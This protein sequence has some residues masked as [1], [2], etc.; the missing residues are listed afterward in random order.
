MAPIV[1][2]PER[3]GGSA[4]PSLVMDLGRL[5]F[6]NSA[7]AAARSRE[8]LLAE[9]APGP[10]APPGAAPPAETHD[11]AAAR[12]CESAEEYASS[13][14]D[15][16][17]FST[18][19]EDSLSDGGYAE[20]GDES[21]ALLGARPSARAR[22]DSNVDRWQLSMSSISLTLRRSSAASA[23]DEEV[24]FT[25][26]EKF[27]ILLDVET[28]YRAGVWRADAAA[29]SAAA[30]V[31]GEVAAAG[32]DAESPLS[33]L[34]VTGKLPRLR[35]MLNSVSVQTAHRVYRQ[36]GAWQ[37]VGR[38]VRDDGDGGAGAGAGAA[39]TA[40]PGIELLLAAD[41]STESRE[42]SVG[43][44]SS[45]TVE[46]N[47]EIKHMVVSLAFGDEH[48]NSGDKRRALIQLSMRGLGA[49]LF[50][51]PAL[52]EWGAHLN[53][54]VVRDRWQPYG[55][56]WH[57]ATLATSSPSDEATELVA[58]ERRRV[59]VD[60]APRAQR[61]RAS[62]AARFGR[63]RD[64]SV[65]C[66]ELLGPRARRLIQ[67]TFTERRNDDGSTHY[68]RRARFH[69]LH[70]E[71][72]PETISALF[73]FK[74]YAYAAPP[75]DDASAEAALSVGANDAPVSGAAAA[76]AEEASVVPPSKMEWDVRVDSVSFCLNKE[77]GARTL[78]VI[79]LS[80]V[81]ARVASAGAKVSADV[82]LGNLVC[83]DP[84]PSAVH[85]EL[86]RLKG[87]G[88]V[89]GASSQQ[90]E[91]A[92]AV[93]F[94]GG[95]AF[96][97]AEYGELRVEL[98]PAHMVY[99]HQT[100]MEAIDYITAGFL[101]TLLATSAA[102]AGEMVNAN[103]GE[104]DLRIVKVLRIN[105]PTVE[106]PCSTESPL[107]LV[108]TLEDGVDITT[109]FEARAVGADAP[110]NDGSD[111]GGD[112]DS[113][114]V[115]QEVLSMTARGMMVLCDGR[116]LLGND[117]TL[118]IRHAQSAIREG[119][120]GDPIWVT[121][122]EMEFTGE[123][124]RGVE[125]SLA[126]SEYIR[127]LEVLYSNFGELAR[128][129]ATAAA[130]SVQYRYG[131]TS[132]PR[133][134]RS[135]LTLSVPSM[136]LRI[137]RDR[138]SGE[139]D[140]AVAVDDACT[141][142]AELDTQAWTLTSTSTSSLSMTKW[143]V[144]EGSIRNLLPVARGAARD[145]VAS[146]PLLQRKHGASAASGPIITLTF[147]SHYDDAG[148]ERAPVEAQSGYHFNFNEVRMILEWDAVKEVADFF[149]GQTVGEIERFKAACATAAFGG[150]QHS[151]VV[152][153]SYG[154]RQGLTADEHYSLFN[155]VF[156]NNIARWSVSNSEIW[157][158]QEQKE[159]GGAGGRC[160]AVLATGSAH[161]QRTWSRYSPQRSMVAL[162]IIVHRRA[163]AADDAARVR[164]VVGQR[165]AE[166]LAVQRTTTGLAKAM[167]SVAV[168]RNRTDAVFEGMRLY[169]PSADVDARLNGA[170]VQR[171]QG[172]ALQVPSDPR[173]SAFEPLDASMR[174]ATFDAYWEVEARAAA[175]KMVVSRSQTQMRSAAGTSGADA[176]AA[177]AGIAAAAAAAL[178]YACVDK[179]RSV[180]HTLK[181]VRGALSWS[182]IVLLLDVY[183]TAA[184]PWSV[185]DGSGDAESSPAAE[186]VVATASGERSALNYS[187][188]AY[189]MRLSSI[190][191]E[192]CND[193]VEW[194]RGAAGVREADVRT[195]RVR[196]ALGDNVG[197][198]ASRRGG[199]PA[200]A[201]ASERAAP[202]R[203]GIAIDYMKANQYLMMAMRCTVAGDVRESMAWQ[204]LVRP[205][206]F[207]AT[208]VRK[209]GARE[210][211][212][213]GFEAPDALDIRITDEFI[214]DAV[215]VFAQWKAD[216]VA[217]QRLH[218]SRVVAHCER[219][220]A[221]LQPGTETQRATLREAPSPSALKPSTAPTARR[222]VRR[223][224]QSAAA[225]IKGQASAPNAGRAAGD[226][227]ASKRHFVVDL[228]ERL[229][230]RLACRS[231][232]LS[233]DEAQHGSMREFVR[234]EL[235]GMRGEYTD[236]GDG[237]K[238]LEFS[239]RELQ[240]A[241]FWRRKDDGAA[242]ARPS[243][244]RAGAESAILVSSSR[245]F[246]GGA[247]RR[248]SASAR[249]KAAAADD[250][251]DTEE[252]L[253]ILCYN[254]RREGPN[255]AVVREVDVLFDRLH[256]EWNPDIVSDVVRFFAAVHAPLSAGAIHADD[257]VGEEVGLNGD[258]AR[259][260]E[261]VRHTASRVHCTATLRSLSLALV[262]PE[263]PTAPLLTVALS[264]VTAGAQY[265]TDSASEAATY[266]LQCSLGD[267][268]ANVVD[269]RVA[270]PNVLRLKLARGGT[271]RSRG[272]TGANGTEALVLKYSNHAT[273]RSNDA[274]GS[275]YLRLQPARFVYVH[276]LALEVVDYMAEGVMGS[277]LKSTA[278][279]TGGLIESQLQAS[280]RIAFDIEIEH[281]TLVVP[282]NL[283]TSQ[284]NSIVA[285]QRIIT[286]KNSFE[287]DANAWPVDIIALD[288]KGMM[289]KCDDQRLLGDDTDLSLCVIR[290]LA[291]DGVD[292]SRPARDAAS[293]RVDLKVDAR[294][295]V[296][297]TFRCSKRAYRCIL[298]TLASNFG[299]K[300][301]LTPAERL[302]AGGG[303]QQQQQQQ[304][305]S[306]HSKTAVAFAG[307]VIAI[308]AAKPERP[309]ELK[310]DGL[311][312]KLNSTHR[313]WSLRY[314]AVTGDQLI[315][316][317]DGD[318]EPRFAVDIGSVTVRELEAHAPS[319]IDYGPF[320]AGDSDDAREEET[321]AT[322][323]Q[324]DG[325]AFAKERLFDQ[326]RNCFVVS[327][328]SK[329]MIL[330]AAS[331]EAMHAWVDS[332]L[333]E[334]AARRGESQ[335]QSQH[336]RRSSAIA[337]E[338]INAGAAPKE[339]RAM[340]VK[341]S[342][343]VPTIKLHISTDTPLA[344]FM[345]DS[346]RV[347]IE[348]G[349]GAGRSSS[350][351][352]STATIHAISIHDERPSAAG[353]PFTHLLRR[354]H[355]S[356][357]SGDPN[358]EST[359]FVG[360]Q[361]AEQVRVSS[362]P[363]TIRANPSH[364]L[365]CF[366]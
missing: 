173:S 75:A 328:A 120:S 144:S 101:G 28:H 355:G 294:F 10:A 256:V 74:E 81:H 300:N 197:R 240:V 171:W 105:R 264:Q 202:A 36:I 33:R 140:A 235:Q 109:S 45:L 91:A 15:T 23:V 351:I 303:Q 354:A 150:A 147:E 186:A 16:D 116:K 83:L 324:R 361:G 336:V 149:R 331:E 13:D 271:P 94:R 113:G 183:E 137:M 69:R 2:F 85:H 208:F 274:D 332:I 143:E 323:A 265:W 97:A 188:D 214:R 169:F 260:L 76:V 278:E 321:S 170:N 60:A 126:R 164:D 68:S 145:E 65:A 339:S 309:A 249:A 35:A 222:R 43:A 191:L 363:V 54:L 39:A 307:A 341:F 275:F 138:S 253:I 201:A 12:E 34:V 71:W 168:M 210:Q 364:H 345:L 296:G 31:P 232:S 110:P 344:L 199:S 357:S 245:C 24:L 185:L 62:S 72:N 213:V 277:L 342:L 108:A 308:K 53:R 211:E 3:S 86:L 238:K 244:A 196:L 93:R 287:V 359:L 129:Q 198:D 63:G 286:I 88:D 335:S 216:I 349:G 229:I 64:A 343:W 6:R 119:D 106:I 318:I 284:Q 270:D 333:A 175:K 340:R 295:P 347:R 121:R 285:T 148:V 77:A 299:E 290:A 90:K 239:L 134:S 78:M 312:M 146:V 181:H 276:R 40:A 283:Q 80:D 257:E 362:T 25:L 179:Q 135:I 325:A 227:D 194:L 236:R 38:A 205:W 161:W 233:S 99:V 262:R 365:I 250:T 14:D 132:D 310:I 311:L 348:R 174:D 11:A 26:V 20:G 180:A 221:L 288:V 247:V 189:H 267:L 231:S 96:D 195:L 215:I 293:Q 89:H 220:R 320:D 242:H 251:T 223:L 46:A 47:F 352:A 167:R 128:T 55:S 346:L 103:A 258:A 237:T 67:L 50:Q 228:P 327:S 153:T 102:S 350:A 73:R 301:E 314:F 51:T 268:V 152:T 98:Q 292:P 192:V 360:S 104:A 319:L 92:L 18:A 19:S 56:S 263:R 326:R 322:K 289:L 218:T 52:I 230:V 111:C 224:T 163:A 158:V 115:A 281:P 305:Q 8:R 226:V 166:L 184:L 9:N 5:E 329:S 219:R 139:V 252:Q 306:K 117:T 366:P 334:A 280:P 160:R 59:V 27:D 123:G 157:A 356:D 7:T 297:I 154:G 272:G 79:S 269:A 255:L 315:Y 37:R 190:R 209:L 155:F 48:V 177:A 302:A 172:Q 58:G 241:D 187:A 317:R 273:D 176:A 100:W 61:R 337:V 206:R 282:E 156:P 353:R 84:S 338:T 254:E 133:R 298:R 182:E 259:G 246:D 316:F 17:A 141:H 358:V 22:A 136:R 41:E 125:A 162:L 42:D 304:Q 313:K 87:F 178:V 193:A 165:C 122:M 70:F 44:S 29:A 1:I 30:S 279:A 57:F 291:A 66:D 127:V 200:Q 330:R 204:P 112:S 159:G 82:Q 32:T 114:A 107:C 225:F 151:P 207:R 49:T 118:S 212:D 248:D 21:A 243:A 95:D 261:A 266:A 124:G 142:I 4:G 217:Y 203:S 130:S 131:Q 234:M